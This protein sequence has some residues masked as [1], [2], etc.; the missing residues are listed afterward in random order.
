MLLN[1][2]QIKE[3]I[4]TYS[5]ILVDSGEFH[6]CYNPWDCQELDTTEQLLLHFTSLLM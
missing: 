2:Q 4:N 1:N 6:G 5:S 3:E